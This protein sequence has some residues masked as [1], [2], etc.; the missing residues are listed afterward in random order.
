ME[1]LDVREQELARLFLRCLIGA[2]KRGPVDVGA[3]IH[4]FREYLYGSF[5]PPEK[6]VSWRP[7][8]KKTAK[9]SG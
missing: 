4:A 6:Y 9:G 2:S 5:S 8:R 1:G 3:F 7:R